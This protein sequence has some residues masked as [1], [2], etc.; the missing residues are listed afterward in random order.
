MESNTTGT[1]EDVEPSQKMFAA[2]IT[3][4]WEEA[5]NTYLSECG[6]KEDSKEWKF[7]SETKH[8]S[9]IIDVVN[10][11]W[12]S[13]N[14]PAGCA[15]SGQVSQFVTSSPNSIEK[16]GVKTKL[17]RRLNKALGRKESGKIFLQP[18]SS[19]A[20]V[21]SSYIDEPSRL[22]EKL[23]GK[24]SKVRN[25][26][27]TGLRLTGQVQAMMGSENIKTVVSRVLDLADSLEPLVKASELVSSQKYSTNVKVGSI[28]ISH[29]G[30]YP[31][32]FQGRLYVMLLLTA[33]RPRKI[34]GN[35][36]TLSQSFS[37]IL[38]LW[39]VES[40]T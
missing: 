10:E 33:V 26:A 24:H 39:D 1:R 3:A 36:M 13:Y 38:M 18:Q 29:T 30:L 17:K 32:L 16:P 34:S 6:L 20:P 28:C 35:L 23:L 7:I 8:F 2:T 25:A 5:R 15:S 21:Q 14:N 27:E 31:V 37:L 9:Q 11:T 19:A 12:A 40:D 22:E 4:A